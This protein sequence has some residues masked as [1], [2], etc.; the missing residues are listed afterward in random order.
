MI[1]IFF[2]QNFITN[3]FGTAQERTAEINVF[4]SSDTNLSDDVMGGWCYI[5]GETVTLPDGTTTRARDEYK[6]CANQ[7]MVMFG[8]ILR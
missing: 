8:K 7:M 6:P 1:V 3:L 2:K 4:I 5:P